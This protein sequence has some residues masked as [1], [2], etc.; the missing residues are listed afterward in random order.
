MC[1]IV[2]YFGGAPNGLTRVLTAMAAI[3]YRA[4]DSTG[5]GIFGDEN[6][7]LKARKSVGSVVQL[8]DLLLKK[9]FYPDLPGWLIS[10]LAPPGD[11][12]SIEDRQFRLLKYE[13]LPL[14][15]FQEVKNG[16]RTYPLFG[17]LVDAHNPQA[18]GIFPGWPGRPTPLPSPK[19]S[20]RQELKETV[21]CL[22]D[23]YDLSSVAIKSIVKDALARALEKRRGEESMEA[24][25]EHVLAAFDRV[26]DETVSDETVPRAPQFEQM[27]F[28]TNQ[29]AG[30][31]LWKIL[32]ESEIEIPE[33]YDTDGVRGVFR[34][35]DAALASRIPG[36][37]RLAER[38][39][40]ELE[41]I[42]ERAD[43]DSMDW[44][45]LFT[46]EKAAN[47]Y[48]WAAAAAMAHLENEPSQKAKKPDGRSEQDRP[49]VSVAPGKTDP[50]ILSSL[51]P[52]ILSQ[53]RWALQSAVTA[54]NGHPFF[55]E[56]NRRMIVLNGQFN[57]DVENQVLA[58]LKGVAR[59]N[60]RTENSSEYFSLLW[61]YYFDRLFQEKE[62]YDSIRTQVEGDLETYDIGS[63]SI[64]YKIFHKVRDKSE[65][66][67]DRIA[68][69]ETSRQMIRGGGQ[70]A[71]AGASLA[72]AST[73]FLTCHNR[74]VF[75]V[76]S[77]ENDD[78]MVVSDINAAMGLFSQ[79]LI[80][81]ITGKLDALKAKYRHLPE[82]SSDGHSPGR[83]GEA[84]LSKFKEEENGLLKNFAV[85]V[86]PLD[87][88]CIFARIAA[89]NENGRVRRTVEITDFDGKPM[90][91]IESFETI[92]R[93]PHIQKDFYTSFYETHLHEIPDRLEEILNYYA[94]D[95][96][97]PP[98]L[99]FRN[100]FLQ[101]RF[102]HR[103][104]GLK[105][106]VLVGMGST[107]HMNL[108]A[109][110]FVE[111]AVPQIE[112]VA[113][114]P[115][116]SEDLFKTISP[117]KDLVVL[118]SWSGTTAEIVQLAN[119]LK[120]RNVPFVAV[121]EKLFSDLG[122]AAA[123]SGG[124]L[125]TM[126]GEEI[127]VSGIKSTLCTLECLC[128]LGVWL[129]GRL[130]CE[131]RSLELLKFLFEIPETLGRM[132]N[133]A[134]IGLFC[135]RI[136]R[137]SA[138][139]GA[140]C[141]IDAIG[142][143]GV[144]FEAAAKL[145]ESSW[146]SAGKAVDYRDLYTQG[147]R[148]GPESNLILVNATYKPRV[149]E[150]I[151]VMKK[152]FLEKIPFAAVT[153][154]VREKAS[155]ETF[156]R[157]RSVCVPEVDPTL[158]P[159]VD[160]AF[161]YIL[162]FHYGRARGRSSDFPRNRAKSVTAA[163]NL[164]EKPPSP[165]GEFHKM[166]SAFRGIG[167]EKIVSD[168]W[169]FRDTVWESSA[170]EYWERAYL[171]GIRELVGIARAPNA[172]DV[173]VSSPDGGNV[174]PVVSH[175]A[176]ALSEEREIVFVPLDRPARAAA[177]NLSVHFN[178]L[179]A[180]QIRTAA[181][182]DPMDRFPSHS[183]TILLDSRAH[184]R[185][186]MENLGQD[187]PIDSVYVGPEYD[188]SAACSVFGNCFLKMP[189]SFCGSD[190]L[191]FTVS[192]MF[193]DALER[194]AP[195]RAGIL[196]RFFQNGCLCFNSIM[197]SESLR[198]DIEFA[199]ESNSGYKTALFIGPPGGAGDLCEERFDQ[200]SPM[201]L[202]SYYYGECAHGPLVT[203]DPDVDKK[204]V[205]LEPGKAMYPKYGK[206][207]VA[208][209]ESRYLGG[210]S[211]DIFLNN[212]ADCAACLDCQSET[213]FFAEGRWYFPVLRKSYDI[214]EDNLVIVDATNARNLGRAKDD[215]STLGARYARMIVVTQEAFFRPGE[216]NRL[217]KFP[218][219]HMIKIPPLFRQEGA[220]V[221][222]NGLLLP[223]AIS[224]VASAL[225]A[226]AKK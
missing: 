189:A 27:T 1:G 180:N 198:R 105:R 76:R 201:T 119:V 39:Q 55:D 71:V 170:G 173:L 159:F 127:T 116:E 78:V 28:W 57:T 23:K 20:S 176:K 143:G 90:P 161:Y 72:S 211:A 151:G 94:S 54:E 145:S 178:R 84:E 181:P 168:A 37:P 46:A 98:N 209:W 32:D 51:L 85:Q 21:C 220:S 117:E 99:P 109:R 162:S 138:K 225:A 186:S 88:E 179:L 64:D 106:L 169:L 193:I 100:G 125:S 15:Y 92:L 121:T 108:S 47:V 183:L 31:L 63:Q 70:I 113:V 11:N 56:T 34:L 66:E 69:V 213:P 137:E 190:L 8:T 58:Y 122:L 185:A 87:G 131:E 187:P 226:S 80:G 123:K 158:Q 174:E 96:F 42:R 191:Y 114:K 45:T 166:D 48:G 199:M 38:L 212:S 115:V 194:F 82:N 133:D 200:F 65:K 74:P 49:E 148:R 95:R 10:L 222:I 79:K 5:I 126:S 132:I 41:R 93:P 139:S 36:D 16:E 107:H 53:G 101:R 153:A 112:T 210:R 33:D 167:I 61:G 62:R 224:M 97:A 81:E 196:K 165:A 141:V 207:T 197:D 204:F 130:Q 22:I 29:K 164:F 118:S 13:R 182:G 149:A 216:K 195:V 67:I 2:A 83:L 202:Q 19:I 155:V 91:D 135:E 7:P 4:P 205:R 184:D 219:S 172:V 140:T 30:E 110:R 128:L 68:F 103:F 154:S 120:A 26:F 73:V 77:L 150:A 147:L 203:V 12:A 206:E 152:L 60:P 50:A 111:A 86:Y 192:L 59:I 89:K 214:K 146:S 136:A 208:D 18:P 177:N 40:G 102:G 160:C 17:E 175:L 6:E 75:I 171:A 14:T 104:E 142:A 134:E 223:V 24:E 129:C 3:I 25:K 144:A 221:P 163:R 157:N 44:K 217:F 43:G 124:V 52:P 215:L 218:V 156:S 9:P 188:V 35:L